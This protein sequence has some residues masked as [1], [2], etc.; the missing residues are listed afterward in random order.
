MQPTEEVQTWLAASAQQCTESRERGQKREK[1]L[2]KLRTVSADTSPGLLNCSACILSGT[3]PFIALILLPV[4]CN[5]AA[6][7]LKYLC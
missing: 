6:I 4:T 2:C 3:L 5:K 7:Q 1:S